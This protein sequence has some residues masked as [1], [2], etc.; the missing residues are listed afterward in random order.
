MKCPNCGKSLWFVQDVCPFCK[1]AIAR[2]P[3][4]A[5]TAAPTAESKAAE[6]AGAEGLVTLT[7]CGTLVEADALRA[8]LEAAGIRAILPDEMLMQTI[9]WN[10][11]TYGFVRVQVSSRDY[12]AARQVLSSMSQEA[13]TPTESDTEPEIKLGELPLSWPMRCFAFLLPLLTCP[14]L[15]IFAITKGGYSSRGCDR[16][17]TQWWHWFAA[18]V[19]FWFLILICVVVMRDPS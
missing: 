19:I 4:P 3:K 18:G 11:N 6:N 16:K 14:G 9:A 10:V 8:R 5:S 7:Q 2:D 17:A 15:I 12:E 13:A 1:T